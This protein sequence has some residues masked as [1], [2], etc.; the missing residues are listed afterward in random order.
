[1]PKNLPKGVSKDLDRHGNWRFYFRASGRPKVRLRERPGTN[2]FE[3]EVACAR[4][5]IPFRKPEPVQSDGKA[6]PRPGT[7][8]WL[9]AEYFASPEFKDTEPATQS[10]RRR[11]LDEICAT[12]GQ[13]PYAR[14]ERRHVIKMRNEKQDTPAAANHLVKVVSVLF[15][16]AIENEHAKVNPAADIKR[17]R[18]GKGFHTWSIEE[19]L[20]YMEAHKPG[21]KARKLLFLAMFTGFRR[22]TLAIVGRQH[23]RLIRNPETG[24]MEKWLCVQPGKTRKSSGVM[25]EIPLLPLL[26]EALADGEAD[27][28]T[29]MVTEYGKP[30]TEAGLGNKMRQW[31]N[32]AGLPHCSLH[33][34]RKAGAVIATENGVTPSQLQA[35]YGWTT[36]QQAERYTR[37]ADRRRLAAAGM[38]TLM[39]AQMVN[40]IVPLGNPILEGGTKR[41]KKA[42][43]NSGN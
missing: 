22:Q 3:E 21:T 29:F 30:F 27:D 33:G 2:A 20:Q 12:K 34:L 32:E 43:E 19:V 39:P 41:P 1:M 11:I 40:K 37:G 18:E 6:P 9:C 42:N 14:M 17:L 24:E 16:W 15:N 4:L 38:K 23:I 8:H 31:C 5:G 28:L 7:F 25:V 10:M 36:L 13:H 35:I 26:E